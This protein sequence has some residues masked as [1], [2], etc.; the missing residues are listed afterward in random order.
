MQGNRNEGPPVGLP[1]PASVEYRAQKLVL[2][3]LAVDPPEEGDRIDDLIDRLPLAG[4]A[5]V[6]AITALEA[7]GLAER[8][9]EVARASAATLYFEYLWPVGL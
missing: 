5:V 4:H 3:E 9:G 6:A 2:L 7:A 1:D 8:H